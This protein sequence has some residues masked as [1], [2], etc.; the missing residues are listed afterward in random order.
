M[1][2]KILLKNAAFFAK[3][4]WDYINTLIR[5]SKF[6]NESKEADIVPVHKRSQNYVKKIIDL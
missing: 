4:I 5:Y 6:H 2:T 1:S 3:Y